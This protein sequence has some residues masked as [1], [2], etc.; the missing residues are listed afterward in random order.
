MTPMRVG[1]VCPYDM[2]SPGG[3][4]QLTTDLAGK[5][6]ELGDEVVL[7]AA[8]RADHSVP[9][10]DDSVIL[11]GRPIFVRGNASRVPLT[12]SPRSWAWGRAALADVDVIHVHEPLIPLV[13][14]VAL[15]VRKPTV[16]TFHADPP[17][18]VGTAYRRTPL[19]GRRFRST[20]IT[21]VSP[22]AAG[23]IP[24][25][26]G[27][28]TIV[29]NAVDVASYRLDTGRVTRR[30]AFL[31]RDEPRKGLDVILEAWSSI[32]ASVGDAE[33]IVMGADRGAA[34]DGIRF[35]GR[36]TGAEKRRLL[37]SSSV[38]VAPNTGGESFGMVLIEAMAAGCAIVASDLP[39]FT[40]VLDGAGRYFT[41][42]DSAAL[43][44]NVIELLN[45]ERAADRLRER[46]I[47][48]VAQFDWEVV[49]RRY[50]DLYRQAAS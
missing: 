32:R 38:F 1:L 35:M 45:D 24:D 28:V 19:L 36:V 30:V 39:A 21:A 18:W 12:L 22:A 8:G 20:L 46:A 5:L 25:S 47:D 48:H 42:G 10:W 26:W 29:P 14:W 33:L 41:N 31:G 43:S 27:K 15:T 11:V 34:P 49:A 37:A 13:G 40:A 6:R 50:R 16:A 4:Q 44:R 23:P 9:R 2:G 17:S 7:V 3:V